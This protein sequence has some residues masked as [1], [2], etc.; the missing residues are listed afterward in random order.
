MLNLKLYFRSQEGTFIIR[1]STTPPALYTISYKSNSGK[2]H[3]LRTYY[4]KGKFTYKTFKS[5]DQFESFFE[6]FNFLVLQGFP[7]ETQLKI[8]AKTQKLPNQLPEYQDF[9]VNSES[10]KLFQNISRASKFS[11]LFKQLS[12]CVQWICLFLCCQPKE[13]DDEISKYSKLWLTFAQCSNHP[14]F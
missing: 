12:Q 14:Y 5:F 13:E 6:L 11:K 2:I 3:S 4:I 1:D 10:E 8:E 7:L 9:M